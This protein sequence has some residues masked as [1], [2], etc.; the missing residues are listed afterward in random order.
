[1]S[2]SAKNRPLPKALIAQQQS[3]NVPDKNGYRVCKNCCR[4][5]LVQTN[6]NKKARRCYKCKYKEEEA[7][8]K[9]ARKLLS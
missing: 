7:D 6:F 3:K 8:R 1:M 2:L 5:L 4:S 9:I